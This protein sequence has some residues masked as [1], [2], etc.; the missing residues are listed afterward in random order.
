M[1]ERLKDSMGMAPTVKEIAD[2]LSIRP[3]S[4]HEALRRLEEKG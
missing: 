1:I 2:A 3:P 4:V